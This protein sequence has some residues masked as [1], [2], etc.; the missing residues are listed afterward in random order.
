[1]DPY[2]HSDVVFGVKESLMAKFE[3]IEDPQAI[4]DAGF[5]EPFYLVEHDFV[6]ARA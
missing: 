2:I 5:D 4:K 3:L 1:D 6:L